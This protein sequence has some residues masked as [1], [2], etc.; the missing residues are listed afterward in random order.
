MF[1]LSSRRLLQSINLHTWRMRGE[2][3]PVA[4]DTALRITKTSMTGNLHHWLIW[5]VLTLLHGLHQ[6]MELAQL[7]WN[8]NETLRLLNQVDSYVEKLRLENNV[9]SRT[10]YFR[11]FVCKWIPYDPISWQSG[12]QMMV[13]KLYI[14]PST[15]KGLLIQ[16]NLKVEHSYPWDMKRQVRTRSPE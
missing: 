1:Q 7:S 4:Y 13:F 2:M 10:T 11:V 6:Q 16:V 12:T 15:F 14:I 9:N 3:C 5:L 8:W